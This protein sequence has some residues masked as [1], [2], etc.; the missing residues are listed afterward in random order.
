MK[1]YIFLN[2]SILKWRML[3][4]K[5]HKLM[6][7]AKEYSSDSPAAGTRFLQ[8]PIFALAGFCSWD[9]FGG[10]LSGL[11]L[12]TWWAP[13]SFKFFWAAPSNLPVRPFTF[14]FLSF[15]IRSVVSA[16]G[17][18]ALRQMRKYGDSKIYSVIVLTPLWIS[19]FCTFV[20]L[21]SIDCPCDLVL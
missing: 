4:R 20:W 6:G 15:S 9:L 10:C 18:A 3:I 19:Y 11:G 1:S 12:Y 14:P 5:Y 17:A 21:I 13:Y 16:R 8:R 2:N 7:K